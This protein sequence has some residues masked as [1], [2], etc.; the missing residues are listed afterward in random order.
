[1]AIRF[2][3]LIVALIGTLLG[4]GA[5]ALDS[6]RTLEQLN[7]TAWTRKDGAPSGVVALAQTPDGYLWAASVKG[8]QR[9]DGTSFEKIL[10]F[11]DLPSRSAGVTALLTTKS[12]ELWIGHLWGGVSVYRDGIFVDVN[13]A[14]PHG[15]VQRIVQDASGAIWIATG[16]IRRTALRRF[17]NGHWDIIEGGD[18]NLPKADF[19]DILPMRDGGILLALN[20]GLYRLAPGSRTFEPVG[21]GQ[22]DVQA[23]AQTVDDTIWALAPSGLRRLDLSERQRRSGGDVKPVRARSIGKILVDRDGALWWSGSD[24]GISR[25]RHPDL[26][27]RDGDREQPEIMPQDHLSDS[28]G[29]AMLEDREGNIWL[30]TAAGLD[31]F[32]A[33]SFITATSAETESLI[34]LVA[35]RDG[36]LYGLWRDMENRRLTRDRAGTITDLTK[37]VD[38]AT[39]LCAARDGGVWIATADRLMLHVKEDKIVGTIPVSVG[40]APAEYRNCAED[41]SGR[42]WLSIQAFGYFRFDGKSWTQFDIRPD[43]K[44]IWPSQQVIDQQGRLLLYFGTR[45]F[46]CVDGD[47]VETIWDKKD[48]SIGRILAIHVARERIFLGGET[49]LAVY[50]G[51]TIKTIASQRFPFLDHLSGIATTGADETW[52]LSTDGVIRIPSRDLDEVFDHPDA[53]LHPRIFNFEDGIRGEGYAHGEYNEIVASRDGRI[54][55]HT[56]AGVEWADPGRLYQNDL[57]PPVSIRSLL[58]GDVR[59]RPQ[60]RIT[61][62]EGVTNL[63]LDYTA[64][65]LTAPNK[66][67]FRYRLIGLDKDWVEAGTRRQAFYT[68]LAPG[69]YR[70]QVIAANN[71]GVWNTTGAAIDL[72]IP[73]TFLQSRGFE[74]LC[75]AATFGLLWLLYHLRIRQIAGRLRLRL[76]VRMEERERIARELHDTLLQSVQGLIFRFQAIAGQITPQE[77]ARQQMERALDQADELLAEGRDRLV[78]L[79]AAQAAGNLPTLF[80]EAAARILT[81]SDIEVSLAAEGPQRDL[82]PPAAEEIMRIGEE[83]LFNTL[84][85]AQARKVRIAIHYGR[86]ALTVQLGDD[87]RGLDPAVL[88]QGG[89]DGHFGLRG[90]RERAAKISGDF[91]L[92]SRPGAGI[93][94]SIAIPASVA[95]LRPRRQQVCSPDKAL[96]NEG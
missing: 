21:D 89:R 30:G 9:F 93:E 69:R 29:E 39:T 20:N 77:P 64:P 59:Y 8:L 88:E 74:G 12:G 1:M 4:G 38:K 14:P 33:V 70:F 43:M 41:G 40:T 46:F 35:A 75:A 44:G 23:L 58:A 62:P 5:L 86:K 91:S 37:L 87:G 51:K 10:D 16:G 63:Q 28:V 47:Q 31:R 78:N 65:S 85:H 45:S 25:L 26:L 76:N 13:P 56:S 84:K 94:L 3:A 15:V 32:K 42:L 54:W 24:H 67:E 71:D 34:T 17:D 55:F 90:M 73:P 57:P 53:Q 6:S 68:N 79:R 66:V 48:I 82:S 19:Y 92:K 83:F 22:G 81:G 60:E 18:W 80:G 7:H 11:R 96:Q 27:G 36:D 52:M 95:Y 2:I 72:E 49:G 50:D 61:L